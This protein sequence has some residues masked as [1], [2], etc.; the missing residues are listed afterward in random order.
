MVAGLR[1]WA[2]KKG[3]W[4]GHVG[5]A[6]RAGRAGS[7]GLGA[8]GHAQVT[9]NTPPPVISLSAEAVVQSLG[10]ACTEGGAFCLETVPGDG[11][12]TD[13]AAWERLMCGC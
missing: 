4:G 9:F 7:W 12:G 3:G 11:P 1:W 5:G 2:G 10:L 6:S 13:A 8:G